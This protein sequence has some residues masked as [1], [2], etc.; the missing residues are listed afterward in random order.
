MTLSPELF[1][2]MQR[3]DTHCHLDFAGNAVQIARQGEADGTGFFSATVTPDGFEH[4]REQLGDLC[5]VRVG[6]GMHPWWIA[7]GSCS[8]AD[9]EHFEGLARGERFIGEIGLDFGKRRVGTE[10][11]QL[12]AFERIC[13]SLEDGGGKTISLHAVHAE[14][15]VLDALNRYGLTRS[16]TCILHWFSGSS[17]QLKRAINLGCYFS[18]GPR[19]LTSKRGRAFVQAIPPTRLLLETDAPPE[20]V[21]SYDYRDMRSQLQ[22]ASDG[23]AALLGP[24]TAARAA[25]AGGRLLP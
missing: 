6:L 3:F 16:C 12:A 4:A 25:S 2:S 23:L 8:A 21:D 22:E 1:N 24:E 10:S 9:L 20:P 17:A 19:M 15:A 7:D 5:N 14:D 18:V 13:A 11:V